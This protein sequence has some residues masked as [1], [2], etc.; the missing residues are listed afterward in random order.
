MGVGWG[1]LMGWSG[2]G[3]GRL[4]GWDGLGP[5]DGATTRRHVPRGHGVQARYVVVSFQLRPHMGCSAQHTHCTFSWLILLAPQEAG[6]RHAQTK[7]LDIAAS[8]RPGPGRTPFSS[9][10]LP[11]PPA[12]HLTRGLPAPRPLA[13]TGGVLPRDAPPAPVPAA[14]RRAGK[15]QHPGGGRPRAALQG[16]AD[17]LAP[18]EGEGRRQLSWDAPLLRATLESSP[19]TIAACIG[20]YPEH[21]CPAD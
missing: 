13:P 5:S 7:V 16:A 14:R 12:L 15:R 10:K 18:G 17:H 11:F 2:M 9:V 6:S 8:A 20:L 21:P 4:M 3:W 1:R 19:H